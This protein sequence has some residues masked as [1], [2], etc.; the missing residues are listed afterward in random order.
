MIVKGIR[1]RTSCIWVCYIHVIVLVDDMS[2]NMSQMVNASFNIVETCCLT[3][4]FL[5][6]SAKRSVL[7]IK[8]RYG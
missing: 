4:L 2:C 1:V 7:R 5:Y 6:A 3:Q 8:F